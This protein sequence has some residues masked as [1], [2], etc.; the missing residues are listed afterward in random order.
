MAADGPQR[1]RR[2]GDGR[3]ADTNGDDAGAGTRG[4]NG[5]GR[6][7]RGRGRLVQLADYDFTW[8]RDLSFADILP[9]ELRL[10]QREAPHEL[11]N[12]HSQLLEY[13]YRY[14]AENKDVTDRDKGGVLGLKFVTGTVWCLGVV[15]ILHST[16]L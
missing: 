16:A 10:S 4:R 1:L 6:G 15:C 2:A 3:G 13:G 12:D 9:L 8:L 14:A 7:G 11:R 5:T